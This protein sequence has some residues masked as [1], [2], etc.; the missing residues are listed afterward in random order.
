MTQTS[1]KSLRRR[2][3]KRGAPGGQG[4]EG[5]AHVSSLFLDLTASAG[6]SAGFF[7][8]WS[9]LGPMGELELAVPSLR[10]L[11]DANFISPGTRSSS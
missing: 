2:G 10:M 11:A 6:P 8:L 5:R 4:G 7:I 3:C 9:F 1:G